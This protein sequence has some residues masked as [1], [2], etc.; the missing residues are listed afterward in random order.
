MIV[1]LDFDGVLRRTGSPLYKLE[2]DLVDRFERVCAGHPAIR[3]VITSSW[4]E[5]MTLDELRRPFSAALR[6]RIIGVT[7]LSRHQSDHGR[8][9]EV[10]AFLK[11][12][13]EAEQWVAIDDDPL[14][15]PASVNVVLTDPTK[16][17]DEGAAGLLR[18]ALA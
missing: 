9:R 11:R 14:H 12:L 5:A 1:F 8:Y 16:G 10:L 4:R 15:Y 2:A 18:E 13:G 17:F 3:I 6:S 7:P